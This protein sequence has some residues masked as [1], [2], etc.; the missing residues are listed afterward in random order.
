[1]FH[2]EVWMTRKKPT[3]SSSCFFGELV[4]SSRASK[5]IMNELKKDG[6][7]QHVCGRCTMTHACGAWDRSIE[8]FGCVCVCVR[9]GGGIISFECSS[10]C[11]LQKKNDI[12]L[13]YFK[14]SFES[15]T[16]P[17]LLG[18][19]SHSPDVDR[20]VG[21]RPWEGFLSFTLSDPLSF[22][23]AVCL[24]RR[25]RSFIAIANELPSSNF[26]VYK[27]FIFLLFLFS[28]FSWETSY[29]ARSFVAIASK[30]P[31][32]NFCAYL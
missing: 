28:R 1:M 7:C 16:S 18:H 30:R 6:H 3:P 15:S 21:R 20:H 14:W 12:N 13:M 11:S 25:G 19:V 27:S 23:L 26:S 31:S 10:I 4:K 22:C 2:E 24:W 5:L 8:L 17:S 32:S 9:E 29:W